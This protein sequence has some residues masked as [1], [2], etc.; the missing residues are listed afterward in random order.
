MQVVAQEVGTGVA[1]MTIKDGEKGALGPPVALLLRWFLHVKNDRYSVFIVV[2]HDALVC[3]R[4][5]GL[6]HPVLFH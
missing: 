3:I 6:H 1:T 2:P 5:V 4:G